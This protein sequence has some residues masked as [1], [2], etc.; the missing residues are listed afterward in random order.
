M[1]NYQF[2]HTLHGDQFPDCNTNFWFIHDDKEATYESDK[3]LIK[4]H[5]EVIEKVFG[6]ME[7]MT[8]RILLIE[9][10]IWL[11]HQKSNHIKIKWQNW[12]IKMNDK[13]YEKWI[14]NI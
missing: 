2:V 10:S 7:K 5:K 1:W 3:T 8:E 6:M 9:K 12:Q 4:E 14:E 11:T 13:I